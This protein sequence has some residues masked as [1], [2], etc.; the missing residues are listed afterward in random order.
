MRRDR[1]VLAPEIWPRLQGPVWVATTKLGSSPNL[2]EK[3]QGPEGTAT[4]RSA[5]ISEETIRGT[6]R[7]GHAAMSEA[8]YG[9]RKPVW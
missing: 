6:P 7:S 8:D 3:E 5:V 1:R 9:P 2:H 4:R